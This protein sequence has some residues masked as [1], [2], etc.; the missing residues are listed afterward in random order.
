MSME[1][2]GILP[3]VDIIFEKNRPGQR[4]VLPPQINVPSAPPLPEGYL[5]H[6]PSALPE[7]SQPDVVRHFTN[8]SRKNFC[9]DTT[10]Y[11]L[12]SCTMKHNPRINEALASMPEFTRLH[13]FM[14]DEQVQGLLQICYELCHAI[15]VLTGLPGVSLQPAAGA[16]GELTSMLIMRAWFDSRGERERC[17]ILIPDT[18]H[19]TNPASAAFAGF[20]P[21]QIPSAPDGNI[22]IDGLKTAIDSTLAGIMITN[23]NTLGLFEKRTTEISKLIHEAGGLVYLDGANF[24]AIMGIVQ[25][26]DFGTD[27]MHL[28]LHKTFSTPHGG[29]GPGSGPI[30]VSKALEPFLPK[31]V[32]CKKDDGTYAMD[33]DRPHSIGRVKGFYGNLSVIVRAWAYI[34]TL[35][36]DGIRKT[37]QIAVLNANYLRARLSKTFHLPYNDYCM[38]EFVLSLKEQKKSGARAL[39][40]AKGLVDYSIHPPTIYFPL[41][42][43]EAM[44]IEPTE[45][46]NLETLNRFVSVMEELNRR[47]MDDPTALMNAPETTPVR[48][49]DEAAAARNPILSWPMEVLK[50]DES[51]P[52][53]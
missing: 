46:E 16:H 41:V 29:G 7:V 27:L 20:T 38:H 9:V 35:G 6:K 40:F 8:L 24:N 53:P 52:R 21:R 18:A 4:A 43:P 49:P 44:M 37:S 34:R 3:D 11:P 12:G 15:A 39:D 36:M 5:R 30:A 25:P 42:V 50:K 31:P 33:E 22:D 10:F 26:A 45:T 51:K 47:V 48:R 28:N 32:V 19:G 13:P 14:P 17:T 1:K 2:T 23:P